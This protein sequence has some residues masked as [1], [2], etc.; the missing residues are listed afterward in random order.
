MENKTTPGPH[1][2]SLKERKL[3]EM[4]GVKEVVS[5]NEDKV[6]LQTT[7]GNLNIKGK[8]LNITKLNLDDGSIKISGFVTS[9]EYLEKAGRSGFLNNLFK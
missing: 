1:S 7:Q 6:I 9:L 5:F 4:D 2:F 3:L 8:E